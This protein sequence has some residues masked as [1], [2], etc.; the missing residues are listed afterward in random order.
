MEINYSSNKLEKILCD[1]K[2]INKEYGKFAQGV[3]SRM[4]ELRAANSLDEIPNF[5]PPRRH[6]L[7][8]HSKNIWGVDCSK[9]YRIVFIANGNFDKNDL[10]SIKSIKILRLEDYH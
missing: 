1:E 9:N 2:L 8:P 3:K 4:S 10:S 5:P 7:Q 6:K